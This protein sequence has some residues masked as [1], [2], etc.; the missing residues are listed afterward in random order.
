MNIVTRF[1]PTSNGNL[2]LGHVFTML[3]NEYFAHNVNGKFIIRI[4]NTSPPASD[5]PEER[6]QS[7]IQSQ[8]NDIDWLKIPVDAWQTQSSIMSDVYKELRKFGCDDIPERKH[9][10]YL[11][12][13]VRLGMTYLPYPFVP[14]QTAERVVMDH[15]LDITHVIRGEDFVTEYSLYRYF[16]WMFDYKPPEMIFLPRLMGNRG[17]ISKTNG[18]YTIAELR[19]A[20]HSANWIKDRLQEAAL[21]Y[22]DN[23]W[24]IY[25][26]KPAPRINI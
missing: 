2:H 24:E 18:G 10:H 3:V 9:N 26:I 21:Y 6:V 1:N 4:D 23:G 11:P 12:V 22:P 5:L 8:M 25:N 20:G 15:M 7:I 16:C 13:F 14:Q 17:D 19:G